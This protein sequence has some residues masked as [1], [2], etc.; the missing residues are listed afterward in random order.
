MARNGVTH[1]S[2]LDVLQ[3]RHVPNLLGVYQH[4]KRSGDMKWASYTIQE[5]NKKGNKG[6]LNDFI[7]LIVLC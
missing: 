4:V 7:L 2:V 1:R 5:V 6:D 3:I